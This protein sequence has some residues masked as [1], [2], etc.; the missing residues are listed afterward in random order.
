[1]TTT[2]AW[3]SSP[4]R[5]RC[6]PPQRALLALDIAEDERQD[7][8]PLY[9]REIID[10]PPPREFRTVPASIHDVHANLSI[11]NIVRGYFG[12]R[13]SVTSWTRTP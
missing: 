5:Q 1:M 6:G 11:A 13:T 8:D 7:L 9:Y 10:S 3:S 4:T 2:C 12:G